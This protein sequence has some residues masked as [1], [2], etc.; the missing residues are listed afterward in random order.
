MA[1]P[2]GPRGIVLYRC[3]SIEEAQGWTALDPAVENKRLATEFY[4]WRG[5]DGFGEPLMTML[6]ADPKAKYQMVRL[7]LVVFKKT[8]KWADSGPAEILKEHS[9]VVRTLLQEGKLRA[10]GP[11]VDE[12]ARIGL[13]P[14]AIGLYVFSAMPLEEA[15]AIVEKDPMVREGYARIVAM[16]WFVADE[17]IPRPASAGSAA[18][19]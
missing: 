12:K 1:T 9:L 13:V 17:V 5:P 19:R 7:P 4:R 6:K 11:F 15:K 3:R 18:P 16:E 10:A 14:G 2:G 8:E